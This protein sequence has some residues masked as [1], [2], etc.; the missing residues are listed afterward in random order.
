[1]FSLS[2]EGKF[3]FL[4]FFF[5]YMYRAGPSNVFLFF[6]ILLQKFKEYT[7]SCNQLARLQSKHNAIQ[8]STGEV[9]TNSGTMTRW[10]WAFLLFYYHFWD[11]YDSFLDR[12]Y[13]LSIGI[14]WCQYFNV[15][16]FDEL[17][18]HIHTLLLLFMFICFKF[19]LL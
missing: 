13:H 11:V 2:N 16:I 1:M 12:F 15:F 19:C 6:L 5:I 7:L 10:V 18:F 3:A 9:I 4:T 17:A 8:K 14:I